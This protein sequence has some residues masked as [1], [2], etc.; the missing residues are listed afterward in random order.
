MH[1]WNRTLVW[2]CV[3]VLAWYAET[4]WV[5]FGL[6]FSAKAVVHGHYTGP[7]TMNETLNWLTQ[8]PILMQ[9][10]SGGVSLD[11]MKYNPAPP[12]PPTSWDLSLSVLASTF[13]E[14]LGVK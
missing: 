10:H 13:P 14:Q 12:P 11:S 4:V 1:S 9:T 2:P 8:L 7:L 6:P 5:C 3:K